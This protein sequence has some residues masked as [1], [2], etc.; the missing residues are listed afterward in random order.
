MFRDLHL[1]V[2]FH[3]SGHLQIFMSVFAIYK[4]QEIKLIGYKLTGRGETNTFGDM[5]SFSLQGVLM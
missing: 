2:W 1:V 5:V 4:A 3:D